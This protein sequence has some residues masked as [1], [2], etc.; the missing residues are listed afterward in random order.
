MQCSGFYPPKPQAC[1]YP[2]WPGVWE[3]LAGSSSTS[4]LLEGFGDPPAQIHL[5]AITTNSEMDSIPS[6]RIHSSRGEGHLPNWNSCVGIPS[7]QQRA[8][9]RWH[10]CHWPLQGC[11]ANAGHQNCL[12]ASLTWNLLRDWF[13]DSYWKSQIN[14]WA[15]AL[16]KAITLPR[17][18]QE[19]FISSNIKNMKCPR[20]QRWWELH[21]PH[22][23]PSTS[24]LLI[25]YIQIFITSR[26]NPWFLLCSTLFPP[27]GRSH[28]LAITHWILLSAEHD[29]FL[30]KNTDSMHTC[31]SGEPQGC[32][33]AEYP[34]IRDSQELLLLRQ[35][36][37]CLI[38]GLQWEELLKPTSGVK[39]QIRRRW[40]RPW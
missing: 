28:Y 33:E 18:L 8:V 30:L 26:S 15:K 2:A 31:R 38:D 10:L 6:C 40:E 37:S 39:I 34:H 5:I 23:A 4:P 1:C 20:R 35:H 29:I 17:N 21:V 16:Q 12:T 24:P 9:G 32:K 11:T 36:C 27:T 25:T 3:P 13:W 14:T 22:T 19:R 7:K